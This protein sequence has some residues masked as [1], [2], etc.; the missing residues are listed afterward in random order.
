MPDSSDW[1]Y[2]IS[3]LIDILQTTAFTKKQHR[4]RLDSTKQIHHCSSIGTTHTEIDDSNTIGTG[5]G[6]VDTFDHW[7]VEP[8]GKELNV[9]IEIGEQYILG[10]LVQR[11]ARISW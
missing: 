1:E 6:H 2:K 10:K 8:F 4:L 11:A 7:H 5:I 3:K 9:I